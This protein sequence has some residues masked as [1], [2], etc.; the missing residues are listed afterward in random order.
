VPFID[1]LVPSVGTWNGHLLS[2]EDALSLCALAPAPRAIA[3]SKK[4]G[5]IISFDLFFLNDEAKLDQ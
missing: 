1:T 2:V 3:K 4:V 5:F